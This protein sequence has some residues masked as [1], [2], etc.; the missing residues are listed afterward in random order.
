MRPS[1]KAA[2][3]N[4]ESSTARVRASQPPIGGSACRTTRVS[5]IYHLDRIKQFRQY[6]LAMLRLD[7]VAGLT[8]S[9]VSLPLAMA[10]AA[11][12]VIGLIVGP[13]VM[14]PAMLTRAA[15]GAVGFGKLFGLQSMGMFAG[16]ATGP[17]LAVLEGEGG[18]HGREGA[19]AWLY[20]VGFTLNKP[21]SIG[22]AR[23]GGKVGHLIV[24]EHAG[25]GNRDV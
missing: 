2:Q 8:V 18:A 4:L 25:A 7:L 21:V 11:A 20:L 1:V 22:A 13:L 10:F 23:P 24:E 15:F 16:M 19:L 12:A 5:V 9:L 14:L 6:T 3:P 17:G